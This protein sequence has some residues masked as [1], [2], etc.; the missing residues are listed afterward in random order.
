MQVQEVGCQWEDKI[1]LA[2]DV[3]SPPKGTQRRLST[4]W[5]VDER[6]DA[7]EEV[8]DWALLGVADHALADPEAG[9]VVFVCP[10]GGDQGADPEAPRVWTLRLQLGSDLLL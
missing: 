1:V 8:H 9:V 5:V 10:E 7:R 4:D 3:V 2:P 6:A